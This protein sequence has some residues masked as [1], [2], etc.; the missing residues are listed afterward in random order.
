[1]TQAIKVDGLV[2]SYGDNNV[3]KGISFSITKGEIVALLG[4][5]GAGKTTTLECI[6]GLRRYDGG[7]IEVDGR[8]GVQLQSSSL[9]ESI[10]A[11]EAYKLFC[12]FNKAKPDY[13]QFNAFG[14]KEL[15]QKRYKDMSTGQKRRLH[16]A[17][18]LI[19]D[20]DIIFLDEPT[21]GLDVEGRA[22]L[23]N[24]IRKLKARGKTIIMASHDMAEIES[25]CDRI[26]I[27]KEGKIAFMGTADELTAQIG[28]VSNIRIK[29]SKGEDM[30]RAEDITKALLKQLEEYEKSGI[31][32]VEITTER[33]TL[34]ERFLQISKGDR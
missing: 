4:T 21:A 33:A 1:M 24:E 30:L 23:H 14:L 32:V 31:T 13:E 9:P 16:L 17:L 29:T 28:T 6:E 15:S 22:S 34:E 19:G 5:N 8:I 2:K 25:L 20:P 3:I 10:K 11:I 12:S 7:S 27:L 26:A 18:A